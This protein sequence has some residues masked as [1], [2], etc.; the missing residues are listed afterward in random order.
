MNIKSHIPNFITLLN[1]L[2]GVISI[3][4]GFIGELQLAAMMIFVAA[5]FDFFDGFAARLL[6]AKSA[7]GVQLDSLAD[8]VS[9]GVAPAFVL[10]HTIEYSIELTGIATWEY[11]PFISFI[12]PLFSALRLAKFNIDEDQQTSFTGMP[13]PAVAILIASF[14]IM[15]MVCLADNKGIYFDIVTNPYFLAAIGVVSSFLMVSKIPMFALKFTSVNWAENQ[16]RYIF[17]ILSVFLII[18]LKLAAIP[19]IIL[20]YL[21]ISIVLLLFK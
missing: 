6:N 18:L 10:F 9:F 15:I 1:L 7:I 14:P 3:Y 5:V 20:L 2:S 17:I 11:L 13:T 12:I 8:M 19:L 4:L 21:I 16:T